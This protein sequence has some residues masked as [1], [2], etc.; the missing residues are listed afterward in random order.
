MVTN[1]KSGVVSM[2]GVWGKEEVTK[3][4]KSQEDP[5]GGVSQEHDHGINLKTG[6]ERQHSGTF[7]YKNINTTKNKVRRMVDIFEGWEKEPGVMGKGGLKSRELFQF[8]QTPGDTQPESLFKRK[9][10]VGHVDIGPPPGPQAGCPPSSPS[11]GPRPPPRRCQG[12]QGRWPSTPTSKC[13][14]P[15]A[16]A[17]TTSSQQAALKIDNGRTASRWPPSCG[18]QWGT[19]LSSSPQAWTTG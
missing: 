19:P 13:P 11:P 16:A 15:P 7:N 6:K 1:N 17:S 9:R 3:S 18:T 2:V 10:L 12:T 8:G 4:V 14:A 5:H